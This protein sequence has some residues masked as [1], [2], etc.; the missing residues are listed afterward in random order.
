MNE[1]MVDAATSA[2]ALETV[3]RMFALFRWRAPAR[4][5]LPKSAQGAPERTP[6][7]QAQRRAARTAARSAG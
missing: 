3:M 2:R 1:P 5:D 7:G 6:A 4:D